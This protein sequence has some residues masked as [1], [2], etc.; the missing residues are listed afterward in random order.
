M[1]S[2]VVPVY[3]AE[4]YIK[5]TI[6]SIIRQSYQDIEI[7]LVDDGSTDASVS[8][9]QK[10]EQTDARLRLFSI[11]HSG[12]G[13]ARLYG[14]SQARGEWVMFV[15]ADDIIDST[16]IELLICLDN[17]K[18]DI[19][20]GT[21]VYDDKIIHQNELVGDVSG[22][23]YFKALIQD[24]VYLGLCAKLIRRSLFENAHV[25]IPHKLRR[26]EDLLILAMLCPYINNMY[27]DN[28][29]CGYH[30][31][32]HA[33]SLT[34]RNNSTAEVWME[35]YTYM[36][37]VASVFKDSWI[38]NAV[39]IMILH[40]LYHFVVQRTPQIINNNSEISEILR[41]TDNISLSPKYVK[42]VRCLRSPL[43]QRYEKVR[44]AVIDFCKRQA[45]RFLIRSALLGKRWIL[46]NIY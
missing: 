45:K 3:N 40:R 27:I 16:L 41:L 9:C 46:K 28:A 25:Q 43:R 18:R 31:I 13:I 29:I 6:R 22:I 34:T 39:V 7:L 2:I 35:L 38:A 8:I 26:N 44:F 12:A 10:Y 17:G 4:E 14:V 32:A 42:I 37:A 36:Q 5:D 19:I 1:V 15:D 23:D 30:Y 20:A 24:H 11:E 21:I 33:G